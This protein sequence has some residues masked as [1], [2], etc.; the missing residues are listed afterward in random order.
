MNGGGC[1]R[2]QRIAVIGAG[3]AG[4]CAARHLACSKKFKPTVFEGTDRVGG[5]WV[6]TDRTEKDE[7]GYPVHSSMY[8]DLITNLPK[9]VMAFPE[10]PFPDSLPSFLHHTNVL[11]YLENYSHHFDLLK[12]IKFHNY[13]EEIKV[14]PNTENSDNFPRWEVKTF[15]WKQNQ[16]ESHVF[17]GIMIC[18]GHYSV[19]SFPSIEGMSEFEGEILHSHHFRTSKQYADKTVVL[20]GGHASGI[21]IALQLCP[22]AKEVVLSHK[23]NLLSPF[24]DNLRQAPVISKITGNGV[25]FKDG[26]SSNCDAIMFCT[27]YKYTFPFLKD[28]IIKS[29]EK[30]R[31]SPLYKHLIHIH[32]PNLSFIGICHTVCPFPQFRCQVLYAMGVLDGSVILPSTE[33]MLLE[34]ENDYQKRVKQGLPFRGSHILAN[35]QW[36]YNDE[37]ADLSGH[38]RIPDSVRL[39]YNLVQERRA[40]NLQTYKQDEFAMASNGHYYRSGV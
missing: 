18:N 33:E 17:D 29:V 27:G 10:F 40:Y 7:N 28:P 25:I 32:Y 8:N 38:E 36:A 24:P 30:N 13:V 31:V 21:D 23:G 2:V 1:A 5:T 15:D 39:L 20:F 9:Q 37:L 11:G 26:T 34:E 35:D 3:A 12:Y 19:P 6:Y 22:V 4:L 16:H 14:I